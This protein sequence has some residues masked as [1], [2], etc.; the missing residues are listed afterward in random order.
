M[1]SKHTQKNEQASFDNGHN[2]ENSA[3]AMLDVEIANLQRDKSPDSDLWQGVEFTIVSSLQNKTLS[4]QARKGH[5]R[6]YSALAASVCFC[7]LM[8][9]VLLT[10]NSNGQGQALIAQLSTAHHAQKQAMLASFQDTPATTMN[11]QEQLK[12]L[13]EAEA[14]IKLALEQ[15]PNNPALINMLKHVYQQQLTIIERVHAPA[16]QKI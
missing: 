5:G 12:D 7:A 8:A 6:W 16:W 15:A 1:S 2:E 9:S 13:D 4:T 3:K 11:W 14:A 10:H